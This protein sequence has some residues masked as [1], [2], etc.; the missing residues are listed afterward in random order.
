VAILALVPIGLLLTVW[1][2]GLVRA[3]RIRRAGGDP[4]VRELVWALDR[5]GHP[6]RDGTTLLD[7][8]RRLA[9]LAGPA[10]ARHVRSLRERRFAPGGGAGTR[11]LDRRALRRGLA[12]GRG[13]LGRLR[14]LI[15]LP[16]RR[17]GPRPG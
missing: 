16:P 6:V 14:A 4:D 2:I 1:L 3:R 8:E 7:L 5:L 12:R 10:A 11:G 15:A 13:P 9:D 17:P